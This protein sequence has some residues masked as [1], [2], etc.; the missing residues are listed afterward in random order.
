M[1]LHAFLTKISRSGLD[2]KTV[3]DVGACKGDWSVEYK[4]TLTDS[5]FFLFEANHKWAASLEE[6]GFPYVCGT[7]LSKPGKEFVEFYDEQST[8]AS[9][10]KEN[11]GWFDDKFSA[12]YACTTL[13][14]I[15]S[16]YNL[17]I[18]D[19]VKL[20]TQGAELDILDGAKSIIGKTTLIYAECPLINFNTGAPNIYEYM[21]YFLNNDYIPIDC[22]E[23]HK[24]ENVF[25]HMDILFMQKEAKEKYLGKHPNLK[26]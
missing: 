17:P 13:D 21:T 5:Q 26:L 14:E 7:V 4:Q 25:T 9:Y 20:D 1:S 23:L 8:G 6:T 3:F 22:F 15:I 24:L 12:K 11:T 19:L 10:Y 2:I 18:P 16:K